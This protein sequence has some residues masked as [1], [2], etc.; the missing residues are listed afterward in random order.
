MGDL[1]SRIE[2]TKLATE[3]RAE[4]SDLLFLV[5]RTPEELRRLRGHVAEALFTRHEDRVL[6]LA[7]LS[8]MLPVPLTAKI[9]E[10]AMGPM[11]SARVA[12]VLDGRDAA[13]LASHLDPK[14]LTEVAVS[15]DPKRVAPIVTALPDDLVVDVGRRLLAKNEHLVL[16]RFVSVVDVRLALTV[17]ESGTAEDLLKVALYTDDTG[18]LDG[19]VQHLPDAMLAEILR[20]ADTTNS[21]DAAVNLVTSLSRESLARIVNQIG[22]VEP[23]SRNNLVTAVDENDVWEHVLPALIE[24]DAPTA[25]ALVNVPRT[26]DV[27]VIDRVLRLSRELDLASVLVH[28][29][30]GM[31]DAHLDVVRQSELVQDPE[32]QTWLIE[33]SGMARKLVEPVI[34]SLT[35]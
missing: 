24:L 29:V 10:L 6:R 13:K 18:A 4:E 8:K 3:L 32:T 30:L 16:A 19:I 17:V 5:S 33:S 11:L 2:V 15:L 27:A 35:R 20:A 28:L 12:G 21:W 26:L 31:D 23:D 34:E 25:A 1:A 7:S 9:A 22:V 14:F